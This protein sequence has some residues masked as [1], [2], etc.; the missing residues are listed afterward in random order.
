LLLY[1]P[2]KNLTENQINNLG[3]TFFDSN[4]Y[5]LDTS[6]IK[7]QEQA[8]D[9]RAKNKSFTLPFKKKKSFWFYKKS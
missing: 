1:F 8:D 2:D 5:N 3:T 7:T 4:E 6:K 9:F